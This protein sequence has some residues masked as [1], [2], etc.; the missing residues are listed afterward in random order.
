MKK[1][2]ILKDNNRAYSFINI[3]KGNNQSSV[4]YHYYTALWNTSFWLVNAFCNQMWPLIAL[5]LQ[6]ENINF[7]AYSNV[8]GEYL[9]VHIIMYVS[10]FKVRIH[11]LCQYELWMCV[12]ISFVSQKT[13]ST[14]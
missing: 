12:S 9:S 8:F 6:N 10:S 3:S 14:D 5:R 7:N 13:W 4:I 2:N 1:I 11:Q